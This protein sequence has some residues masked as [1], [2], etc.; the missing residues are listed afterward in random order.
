MILNRM[1]CAN[2]L[3]LNMCYKWNWKA[4]LNYLQNPREEGS[5]L[6]TRYMIIKADLMCAA[7]LIQRQE[8]TLPFTENE[9]LV[10]VIINKDCSLSV[11]YWMLLI[12]LL[13]SR[14]IH[15]SLSVRGHLTPWS[16]PLS[17][18]STFLGPGGSKE[19]IMVL[20]QPSDIR[21]L[22]PTRRPSYT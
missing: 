16:L 13:K 3:I 9:D 1:P 21:G 5:A 14:H 18:H 15:R 19:R 20:L 22:P 17:R 8:D 6:C 2:P 10:C 7:H 11:M 4:F 12:C